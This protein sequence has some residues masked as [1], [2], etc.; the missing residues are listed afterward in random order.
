[1]DSFFFLPAKEKMKM[2][3][4]KISVGL[5]NPIVDRYLTNLGSGDYIIVSSRSLSFSLSLFSF[6][7]SFSP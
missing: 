2:K 3:K 1:M 6:S 4:K 5:L 7:S